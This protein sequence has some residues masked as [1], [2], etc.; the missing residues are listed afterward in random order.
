MAS[1]DPRT[2]PPLEWNRAPPDLPLIFAGL[3]L[4]TT[5]TRLPCISSS[6]TY[7]TR[8]EITCNRE[9]K[10]LGGGGRRGVGHA[11]ESASLPLSFPLVALALSPHTRP[12]PAAVNS[13]AQQ[14]HPPLEWIPRF[15][16]R[17]P[18][19]GGLAEVDLLEVERVGLRVPG[20]ADNGAD[21]DVQVV[22]RV[23]GSRASRSRSSGSRACLLLLLGACP[24]RERRGG[25]IGKRERERG[26]GG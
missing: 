2:K 8:P 24:G 13:R 5:A 9:K 15:I 20:A 26:S 22:G 18:G 12:P 16:S 11:A 14:S 6:G 17:L 25:V 23:L 7:L 19:P 21:A 1:C 3:R 10:E 4:Q